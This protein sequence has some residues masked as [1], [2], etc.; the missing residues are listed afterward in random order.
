MSVRGTYNLS[1]HK[2]NT[3]YVRTLLYVN[4]LMVRRMPAVAQ[5]W[6]RLEAQNAICGGGNATGS[7]DRP[8]HRG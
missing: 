2:Y 6:V 4:R 8:G 7:D 5:I 1:V 3:Y